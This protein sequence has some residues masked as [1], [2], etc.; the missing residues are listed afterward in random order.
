MKFAIIR[1][2]W[3]YFMKLYGGFQG[4]RVASKQES[5]NFKLSKKAK[6]KRLI[7][8][9]LEE[10]FLYRT[11]QLLSGKIKYLFS[12]V[13]RFEWYK[14]DEIFDEET[15]ALTSLEEETSFD[16]VPVDNSSLIET[17]SIQVATIKASSFADIE[18][19]V[20]YVEEG[21]I[22][23]VNY[24]VLYFDARKEFDKRL[25][26]E[27]MQLGTHLTHISRSEIVCA[28]R[29]VSIVDTISQKKE[30]KIYELGTI[31]KR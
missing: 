30:G 28:G 3:G 7:Q 20:Y 2:K 4:K 6:G 18:D 1:Y 15:L 12:K 22:V 29:Q 13:K 5:R 8:K 16:D 26:L 27:L 17:D 14:N 21:Y 19:I 23:F 25:S 24:G 10:K 9:P 11:M 31:M